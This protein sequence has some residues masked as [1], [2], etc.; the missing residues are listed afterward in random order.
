MLA[1]A[2]DEGGHSCNIVML[3]TTPLFAWLH[4]QLEISRAEIF[5][6]NTPASKFNDSL[7]PSIATREQSYQAPQRQR[8][9]TAMRP[10]QGHLDAFVLEHA[11]KP[12]FWLLGT[13]IIA[14]SIGTLHVAATAR[15][16]RHRQAFAITK[17][18]EDLSSKVSAIDQSSQGPRSLP[19]KFTAWLVP[20]LTTRCRKG[21]AVVAYLAIL[22]MQLLEGYWFMVTLWRLTAKLCS[23]WP[24]DRWTL[25]YWVYFLSV[26][27]MLVVDFA[28]I[29]FGGVIVLVQACCVLELVLF[30]TDQAAIQVHE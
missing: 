20:Y 29:V 4:V 2:G 12:Q 17:P 5:A 8:N 11:L 30:K 28:A 10:S 6:S 1:W 25:A 14:V 13:F 22:G 27:I 3:T 24:A 18:L 26:D 23:Q 19:P 9:R 21:L 16:D 15:A 7:K